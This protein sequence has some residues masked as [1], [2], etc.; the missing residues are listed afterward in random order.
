MNRKNVFTWIV[1]LFVA[2]FC[3]GCSH[4]NNECN[5]LLK[6]GDKLAFLGD[7]ITEGGTIHA[8][9]Y[10]NFVM[11]GLKTMGLAVEPVFAGVSGNK[12]NDMLQRLDKD[13]IA[14]HPQWMTVSCGI[15]DIWHISRSC[16]EFR[17][18]LEEIV[19]K[20]QEDGINLVLMTVTLFGEGEKAKN[21]PAIAEY[22]QAI[23][24]IA[25]RYNCHVADT[26]KALRDEIQRL[27]DQGAEGDSLLTYDGIH[28]KREGDEVMAETI[29]RSFGANDEM[30]AKIKED[31][32]SI[33][34]DR[35]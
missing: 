11:S 30:M 27:H 26:G 29:L 1:A 20:S 7:S 31:W 5:Y 3:F 8:D 17:P 2:M 24:E 4:L 28:M 32:K 25:K 6:D 23:Y 15:N 33:P 18:Y 9:G 16:E 10:C 19:R 34:R 13:V 22:N 21:E 12:S 35:R 14:Y